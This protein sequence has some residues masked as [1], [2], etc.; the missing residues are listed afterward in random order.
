ML[1]RIYSIFAEIHGKGTLEPHDCMWKIAIRNAIQL[2]GNFF[3]ITIKFVWWSM[4]ITK[5]CPVCCLRSR[6][7]YMMSVRGQRV[8]RI[9]SVKAR[10]FGDVNAPPV[11]EIR[12][13]RLPKPWE[14]GC[15]LLSAGIRQGGAVLGEKV[16]DSLSAMFTND[17]ATFGD[18]PSH[19]VLI[20]EEPFL[21]RYKT[22]PVFFLA[23]RS[24]TR[25]ERDA[26]IIK[27]SVASALVRLG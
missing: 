23:A 16:R 9:R 15:L 20:R 10:V 3:C 24:G 14:G 8:G 12:R 22:L 17:A 21:W 1:V 13:R 6:R 7:A 2:I 26:R 4:K 19:T 5:T 27:S 11:I 25:D 18:L